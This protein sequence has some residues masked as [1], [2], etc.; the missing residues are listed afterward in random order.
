MGLGIA[1]VEGDEGEFEV[2]LAE[3]FFPEAAGAVVVTIEDDDYFFGLDELLEE[4]EG[5]E[6]FVEGDVGE[7]GGECEFG[8]CGEEVEDECA[9]AAVVEVGELIEEAGGDGAGFLEVKGVKEVDEGGAG[10]G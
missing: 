8:L 1:V 3:F 4:L 6:N 9:D 5:S 7:G 2:A 10:G